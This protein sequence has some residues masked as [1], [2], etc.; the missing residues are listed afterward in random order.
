M[1]TE[2]ETYPSPITIRASLAYYGSPLSNQEIELIYDGDIIQQ[3][4]TNNEGVVEFIDFSQSPSESIEYTLH[5][6]GNNSYDEVYETFT[7]KY[8]KGNVLIQEVLP[9]EKKLKSYVGDENKISLMFLSDYYS[10]TTPIENVLIKY[11]GNVINGDGVVLEELNGYLRSDSHGI[12]T[13]FFSYNQESTVDLTFSLVSE[14]YY[15]NTEYTVTFEWVLKKETNITIYALETYHPDEPR[16]KGTVLDNE[17]NRVNGVVDFYVNDALV[18]SGETENGIIWFKNNQLPSNSK[19]NYRLE[20]KGNDF[21]LPSSKSKSVGYYKSQVSLIETDNTERAYVGEENVV[22]FLFVDG[23]E[24]PLK[25]SALRHTISYYDLN[26][27]LI[28]TTTHSGRTDSEGVYTIHCSRNTPCRAEITCT[29]SGG[30]Y[31]EPTSSMATCMWRER[32]EISLS[33]ELVS[34]TPVYPEPITINCSW[35]NNDDPEDVVAGHLIQLFRNDMFVDEAR[36]NIQGTVSFTDTPLPN[37]LNDSSDIYEYVLVYVGDNG[38]EDIRETVKTIKY[39]NTSKIEAINTPY[40]GYCGELCEITVKLSDNT[41]VLSGEQLNLNITGYENGAKIPI[42]EEVATQVV[43]VNQDGITTIPFT[44]I[45]SGEYV[46]TFTYNGNGLAP[47][48]VE[49]TTLQLNKVPTEIQ[50]INQPQEI[51]ITEEAEITIQLLNSLTQEPIGNKKIRCD[52][53]LYDGHSTTPLTTI[54][55]TTVDELIKTTDSDGYIT[56]QYLPNL[57]GDITGKFTFTNLVSS[58]YEESS[59]EVEVYWELVET[60]LV[61]SSY[62]RDLEVTTKGIIVA[63][64]INKRTGAHI[65]GEEISTSVEF[66]N[67]NY[68]PPEEIVEGTN[69]TSTKTTNETGRVTVGYLP[70]NIG[71]II[72]VFHLNFYGNLNYAPAS[73]TKELTW[74]KITTALITEDVTVYEGRYTNVA[75]G[76]IDWSKESPGT[77]PNYKNLKTI[78]ELPS[79]NTEFSTVIGGELKY[80]SD[81]NIHMFTLPLNDEGVAE[82]RWIDEGNYIHPRTHS[83][84]IK[85]IFEETSLFKGCEEIFTYSELERQTPTVNLEYILPEGE[86]TIQYRVP[87]HIKITMLDADNNPC[88]KCTITCISNHIIQGTYKL[89]NQG[90]YVKA[91]KHMSS[92]NIPF[93]VDFNLDDSID[94]YKPLEFVQTIQVLKQNLRVA[95]TNLPTT[96][97]INSISTASSPETYTAEVQVTDFN[98]SPVKNVEV[99]WLECLGDWVEDYVWEAPE[100]NPHTITDSNGKTSHNFTARSGIRLIKVDYDSTGNYEGGSTIS[101]IKYDIKAQYGN[102]TGSTTQSTE[103]INNNIY[104]NTTLIPVS[105]GRARVNLNK[106]VP[107]GLYDIKIEYID[108]TNNGCKKYANKTIYDMIHKKYG[109]ELIDI[110][111][112][113]NPETNCYDVETGLSCTLSAKLLGEHEELMPDSPINMNVSGLQKETKNTNNESIVSQKHTQYNVGAMDEYNYKFEQTRRIAQSYLI[114]NKNSTKHKVEY[115]LVVYSSNTVHYDY[116]RSITGLSNIITSETTKPCSIYKRNNKY[117][118][119]LSSQT[120]VEITEETFNKAITI[121]SFVNC[122]TEVNILTFYRF[123]DKFTRIP[124]PVLTFYDEKGKKLGE[125]TG[126]ADGVVKYKIKKTKTGE[127]PLK[128]QISNNPSFTD[129]SFTVT[130]NTTEQRVPNVTA[131]NVTA[132]YNVPC[133]LNATLKDPVSGRNLQNIEVIFKVG[134]VEVGK[135]KTNKNGY[136][137][138]KYTPTTSSSFKYTVQIKHQQIYAE[139]TKTFDVSN[140]KSGITLTI[141]TDKTTYSSVDDIKYSIKAVETGTNKVLSGLSL[142]LYLSKNGKKYNVGTGNYTTDK[143]GTITVTNKMK[144]SGVF[145]PTIELSNHSNYANT[146]KTG[147]NITLT[148]LPVEIKALNNSFDG[149]DYDMSK[150]KVTSTVNKNTQNLK[151]KEVV[152]QLYTADEKY[153]LE[154]SVETDNSGETG[155]SFVS[156]GNNA[157]TSHGIQFNAGTSN[158]NKKY[159][160]KYIFN[161]EKKGEKPYPEYATAYLTVNITFGKIPTKLST[162]YINE[163]GFSTTLTSP[164]ENNKTLNNMSIVFKEN[165]FTYT[166]KTNDKGVATL[167][168]SKVQGGTHKFNITYAGNDDYQPTEITGDWENEIIDDCSDMKSFD[169]L[170]ENWYGNCYENRKTWAHRVPNLGYTYLCDICHKKKSKGEL[171]TENGIHAPTGIVLRCN[172]L[173]T[174]LNCT[175]TFKVKFVCNQKNGIFGG[176]FGLVQPNYVTAEY[177]PIRYEEYGGPNWGNGYLVQNNDPQKT[178]WFD[179][180]RPNQFYDVVFDITQINSKSAKVKTSVNGGTPREAKYAISSGLHPYCMAFVDDCEVILREIR[181]KQK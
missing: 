70:T 104:K 25:N 147:N 87:Y 74:E 75:R 159:I 126:N 92:G 88:S 77:D 67:L 47:S 89:N 97:D 48:T 131:T 79:T 116:L 76:N 117:Y 51:D 43:T 80:Y 180:L 93:E 127:T 166:A 103:S 142:K 78:L 129:D 141:T 158:F 101:Y 170:H 175:V 150:V 82:T 31:F 30:N 29:Y 143:N 39:L 58:K 1:S 2:E 144:R 167:P 115:A 65:S 98:G 95:F 32:G 111:T 136:A 33:Y 107:Q 132:Q 157:R 15:N 63:R 57:W 26:D 61:L 172:K 171:D 83:F 165:T 46:F 38:Y 73:L 3:A 140:S 60:E 108:S 84:E 6:V 152:I 133:T 161:G 94:K 160:A 49:S 62:S 113:I 109:T 40:E 41:G 102:N 124:K 7:I 121:P 148:E 120:P 44:S 64:L 24:T 151:Y 37:D 162:P 66:Y 118:V 146:T 69:I 52:L 181:L 28:T 128:T 27:E 119:E 105:K 100:E 5:Y 156:S 91:H 35:Q 59:E 134:T 125:S 50:I 42:T 45:Y 137:E 179:R 164:N 22:K 10:N 54:H 90:V 114:L 11:T 96:L 174:S 145:T 81:E 86:T 18:A 123:E 71:N 8:K 21:Y 154:R 56:I 112:G 17:R 173:T 55:S 14:E 12:I 122:E 176:H 85:V 9:E 130:L 163:E 169:T 153:L 138:I 155:V 34:N 72:G 135:V 20:F 23:N 16:V 168:S 13:Y 53:T 177:A 106:Y 36:T 110:N 99:D 4:H 149:L 68:D 178:Q 19:F 139:T